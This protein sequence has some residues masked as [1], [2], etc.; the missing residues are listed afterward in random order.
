M[1]TSGKSGEILPLIEMGPVFHS[2]HSGVDIGMLED[3]RSGS[4]MGK[5]TWTSL[6]SGPVLMKINKAK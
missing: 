5:I 3:S 6:R 2:A 1:R 4:F